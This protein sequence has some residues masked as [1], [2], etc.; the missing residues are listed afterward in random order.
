M[1]HIFIINPKSGKK[2][3]TGDIVNHLKNKYSHL[4]YTVYITQSVGDATRYVKERCEN[5]TEPLKFYACGG[6]G[7]VNEVVNGLYGYDDVYF[8]VYPCGSGND[9]VKSFGKEN[10]FL[11]LDRIIEGKTKRIDVIKV[12]DRYSINMCNLG[13]DAGVAYNMMKFKKWPLING[14]GAYNLAIVYSLIFK[15]GHKC[16]IYIDEKEVFDGKMLLSAL[17]NGICCGGAYYCLPLASVE[18]GLID[19][20]IV[21]KISRIRFIG[22]IK[23]YK[24]GEYVNIPKYDKVM[25][26]YKF[27]NFKLITN[28]EIVYCVD[29]ECSKSKEINV[30]II[31]NAINFVLPYDYE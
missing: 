8:T 13:F 16:K 31:K 25:K 20:V 14:K 29:G 2:D 3:N 30:N 15:M 4:R 9:F 23:K 17:G 10:Y 11:D 22:L 6:D 28:K 26:Y 7:T 21:K 24:T 1:E 19:G 27:T 5:K 12:N 18:D